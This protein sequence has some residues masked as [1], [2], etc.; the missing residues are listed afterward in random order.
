[1]S[2]FV[3]EPGERLFIDTPAVPQTAKDLLRKLEVEDAPLTRQREKVD[4][5]LLKR[6]EPL[7]PLMR[8]SLKRRGFRT[9]P[10]SFANPPWGSL[11]TVVGATATT[12][13]VEMEPA[14]EAGPNWP[15]RSGPVRSGV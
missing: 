13:T 14:G 8:V 5:W 1:V 15:V 4:A 3:W 7:D 11:V 10:V 6:A 12:A 9:A 2:K